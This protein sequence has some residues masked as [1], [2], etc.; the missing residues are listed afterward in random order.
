M[1]KKQTLIPLL[2]A[3]AVATSAHAACLGDVQV[4]QM[5]EHYAARTPAANP[6]GLS[7]QDAACTRAKFNALLAQKM[8][9]VIGYKAGLTNPA[10]QK[11]FNTD[12]PVWG[13][14]Y[15][16]MLLQNGATVPAAFGA[17]PLYEADLLVRVKD[18]RIN[19][20]R[21]PIEVLESVDQ[22]I[23]FIELPDLMVQAPPKLNGAGVTA[24]NVGA[25]LGV[26]GTP[27]PVP[28]TRGERYALLN[29]LQAM[30]VTLTDGAGYLL[31]GGKGSD[32][33]EHPLNAVVWL[34]EALQKEEITLQPGDLISLGSFSA[35][36]PPKPGLKV[37]A[38]YQGLPGAQPVSL[39]FE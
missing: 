13:K 20:A 37:Q 29:G 4:A 21:T 38:N 27:I 32:V 39:A 1:R 17:R 5:V 31:G 34:A 28:V 14:L 12:Q 25:R 11:R 26:V 35:L 24:I 15:E 6:E 33:L 9:K 16:G 36:L 19:H 22:V 10:V 8:G 18:R 3:V 2:L 30:Q 23:P 7:D